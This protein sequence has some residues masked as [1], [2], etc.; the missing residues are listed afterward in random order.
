MRKQTLCFVEPGDIIY[1]IDDNFDIRSVELYPNHLDVDLNDRACI[2]DKVD[3]ISNS[4]IIGSPYVAY[5]RVDL[6]EIYLD[7]DDSGNVIRRR[8]L[9]DRKAFTSKEV[10]ET[11]LMTKINK[12]RIA[13]MLLED[14]NEEI[15]GHLLEIESILKKL[16]FDLRKYDI[17]E[18]VLL[19]SNLCKISELCDLLDLDQAELLHLD[20]E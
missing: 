19:N 3:T 18:D 17:P 14:A 13:R 20:K 5:D 12:N 11:Y 16:S 8:R 15:N 1:L 4:L 9:T 2:S 6:L 10:A 7:T